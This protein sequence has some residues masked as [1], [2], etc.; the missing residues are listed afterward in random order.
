[1]DSR[2]R[3]VAVALATFGVALLLLGDHKQGGNRADAEPAEEAQDRAPPA[4]TWERPRFPRHQRQR[5]TM[6]RTQIARRGVSNAAVLAAMR[7]V[8]RHAFVPGISIRAAY[9]DRPLF[10]GHGQTISQPYIVAYMT[11]ALKLKP[12]HKVLEI[13]TGSG[14]QAAVLS[15]ITPHVFTIEIV[16]ALGRDAKSRLDRLGY[17]TVQCKVA[18]GYHGWEE[19]AP[20]DAIIVTCAAGS[21]PPPLV[22]QLK[23]GGRMCIPVGPPGHVQQLVLLTRDAK[24]KVRSRSLMPVRFVPLTRRVR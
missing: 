14:Y 2:I 18:D 20:F 7:R 11:A 19:H 6:A 8:P 9:A 12:G 15:E 13:G 21:V 16:R 23:P 24:G 3:L 1:M 17:K 5:D 22:R 4:L 10:I